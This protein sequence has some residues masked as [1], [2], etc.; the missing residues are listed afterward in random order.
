MSYCIL[1]FSQEIVPFR[2][3]QITL[4]AVSAAANY[5]YVCNFVLRLAELLNQMTENNFYC[6]KSAFCMK[7]R[8]GLF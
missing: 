2:S 5:S 8:Q 7:K 4:R 3:G 6:N 1:S